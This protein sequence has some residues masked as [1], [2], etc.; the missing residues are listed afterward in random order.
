MTKKG[1][2]ERL[3]HKKAH[4]V[5]GTVKPLMRTQEH[6]PGAPSRPT[7]GTREGVHISQGGAKQVLWGRHQELVAVRDEEV[8][9]EARKFKESETAFGFGHAR[10]DTE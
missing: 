4:D 10:T 1:N 3:G 6:K 5:D 8:A 9:Q 7:G 2:H